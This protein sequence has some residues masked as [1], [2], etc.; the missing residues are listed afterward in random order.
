[1]GGLKVNVLFIASEGN[2]FVKTGGL[3]DV[4]G[5]LPAALSQKG[6]NV[7]VMLPNYGDIPSELK[8]QMQLVKELEVPV[9]WRRK[10]CGLK[11]M[12]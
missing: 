3:A 8:G 10:Y 9:G 4:I 7:A 1:M 2:P 5:S 12:T 6:V 11:K